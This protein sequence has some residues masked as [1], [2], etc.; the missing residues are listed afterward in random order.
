MD[1]ERKDLIPKLL[2]LTMISILIMTSM[3]LAAGDAWIR[4][5]DMPTARSSLATSAVNGKIYAIG[6][7]TGNGVVGTVEEYDPVIDTWTKKANM[8][9]A[10]FRLSTSVV[11]GIIYA[12][13][14][15]LA[16]D[17]TPFSVVEAYDPAADLWTIKSDMPV[18]MA[19]L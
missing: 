15:S 6:G 8:P 3:C 17:K 16:D 5:A 10:R 4:K 7:H 19:G 12:F 2:G 9:T 11:D 18:R 14:G 1:F 13:G